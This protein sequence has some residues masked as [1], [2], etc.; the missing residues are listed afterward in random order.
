MQQPLLEICDAIVLE[1]V[2]LALIGPG[3]TLSSP[4]FFFP[5]KSYLQEYSLRPIH[6]APFFSGGEA[7]RVQIRGGHGSA[8]WT[9]SDTFQS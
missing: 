9:G 8:N 5:L 6:S 7:F 4:K 3:A 1:M 2:L